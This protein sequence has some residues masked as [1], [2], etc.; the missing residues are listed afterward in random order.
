MPARP[1]RAGPQLPQPPFAPSANQIGPSTALFLYNFQSK[2]L[3]GIFAAEGGAARDLEP[4]AWQAALP[5]A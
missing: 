4:G 2:R 3:F 5:P 1:E